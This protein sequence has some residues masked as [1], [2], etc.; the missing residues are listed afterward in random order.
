MFFLPKYIKRLGR[1]LIKKVVISKFKVK[2]LVLD[3]FFP[4]NICRSILVKT[5]KS[6][7]MVD[8]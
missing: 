7:S 6:N 1:H 3:I 2:K 8:R 4:S 5:N